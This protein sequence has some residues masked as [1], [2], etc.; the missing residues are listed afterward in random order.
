MNLTTHQI[1]GPS[2]FPTIKDFL[3]YAIERET[4]AAPALKRQ[5]AWLNHWLADLEAGIKP[6]EGSIREA[7][8]SVEAAISQAEAPI[9]ASQ[10]VA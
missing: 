10:R 6:T 7:L 1:G 8:A 5:R 3:E 2:P 4:L 9:M